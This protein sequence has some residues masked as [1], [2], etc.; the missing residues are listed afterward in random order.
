VSQSASTIDFRWVMDEGKILLVNLSPQLEE[1]SRLIASVLIGR[2]LL[3]A[4][5]RADTPRKKRRPFLLYCD[6]YQSYATSD[7]ATF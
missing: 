4:F 5:S 1:P 6:E 3:A 2:L 7:F